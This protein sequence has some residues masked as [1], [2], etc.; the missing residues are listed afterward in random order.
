MYFLPMLI[1]EDGVAV[2]V[3]EGD[4]LGAGGGFVGF[5][6]EGDALGFEMALYG[7]D[8]VEGVDGLR[9]FVP[10]WRKGEDV[11]GEHALKDADEGVSVFHDVV[12]MLGC[13]AKSS[14][15][16]FFVKLPGYFEVFDVEADG[17]CA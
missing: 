12:A 10:A 11:V 15:A 17:K 1:D 8:V 6:L 14:E 16:E 4:V 5:A 7:P 13:A 9:A 3:G 2:G